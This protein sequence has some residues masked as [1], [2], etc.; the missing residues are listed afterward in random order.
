MIRF[1][2]LKLPAPAKLNLMLNIIG[3]REDGYH[4]LQTLYQF[5]DFCDEL[6]FTSRLDGEIK[7]AT[8]MEGVSPSDNLILRAAKLL[9]D[10]CGVEF[11]GATI[12]VTKRIPIGAGLGG[13][14]SNAA[15]T[16]VGL[17]QLW[18]THLTIGQLQRLGATLGA[19]IPIFI[20]GHSAWAEGIGDELTTVT[21]PERWYVVVSPQCQV[22]TARIFGHVDLIRN[23]PPTTVDIILKNGGTNDCQPL[24]SKLYPKVQEALEWLG[25]FAKAQMT[26]TGS[27]VFASFTSRSEAVEV[28]QKLP[29]RFK[30]FISRG[31]NLSP[32]H[33]AGTVLLLFPN[34][35]L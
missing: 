34:G 12:K 9:Q 18:Q 28:I 3:R 2:H 1:N 22:L 29:E 16:L 35:R 15:T 7:L 20:H 27:S 30:G 5:L 10:E 25:S 24:V 23:T 26:G 13:G 6:A 17:N 14:S 21:I 4:N 11:L 31:L 8:P 33:Q 19:D 32:L